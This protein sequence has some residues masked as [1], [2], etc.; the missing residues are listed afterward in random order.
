M[1]CLENGQQVAVYCDGVWCSGTYEGA[2]ADGKLH[3]VGVNG[4]AG[5][6]T[7]GVEDSD[8]KSL[9][10][11]QVEG[12]DVEPPY[13]REELSAEEKAQ[14]R[15]IWPRAASLGWTSEYPKSSS[16]TPQVQK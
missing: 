4:W 9:G 12:L 10:E 6:L 5:V 7:W 8:I 2:S 14:I 15:L 1:K 3:Q 13:E 11:A 16:D